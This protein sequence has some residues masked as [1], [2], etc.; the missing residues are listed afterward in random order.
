MAVVLAQHNLPL[1]IMDHLSPRFRDIFPD[2]NIAKSFSA[3]RTK[4]T[5][6]LNMTLRPHF[7]NV[8]VQN[9]KSHPFSLA[10]DG[11]ND[12]GLQK[13]NSVTVGRFDSTKG[14]VCTRVLNMCLTKGTEA[15]TA[16]AI[17]R[18]MDEASQDIPW[19]NCIGVSVDNTSVNMG[20]HNS[21]RSRSLVKNPNI[22]FMGCPYHIVHN[23]A[24]KA[25][26]VFCEVSYSPYKR[27]HV[28]DT[29]VLLG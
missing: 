15:G 26:E 6:I 13:M 24:H 8:L 16:E 17:F 11:S 21:I 19:K 25:G 10:I 22:Y 14:R 1:A 9:M 28:I 5:C 7:E 27:L 4:S 20:R 18:A 29:I 23:T 3:A 2:S 12:T